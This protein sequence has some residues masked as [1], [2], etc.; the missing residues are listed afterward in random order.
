LNSE[1]EDREFRVGHYN[2][3]KYKGKAVLQILGRQ[4]CLT[5]YFILP[6]AKFLL[7]NVQQRWLGFK[8]SS[9]EL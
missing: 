2:P 6:H 9:S 7:A 5:N 4:I 8:L 3:Q 1:K